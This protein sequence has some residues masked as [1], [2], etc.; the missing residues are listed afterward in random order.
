MNLHVISLINYYMDMLKI[1]QVFDLTRRQNPTETQL[2][3]NGTFRLYPMKSCLHAPKKEYNE[4]DV[5]KGRLRFSKLGH[6][7]S[8]EQPKNDRNSIER[9]NRDLGTA[10]PP[11]V[12]PSGHSTIELPLGTAM[13]FIPTA[14]KRQPQKRTKE[15][16]QNQEGRKPK[17]QQARNQPK[18]GILTQH[19][20]NATGKNKHY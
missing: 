8:P 7:V 10:K 9:N 18:K 16:R 20:N 15:R 6:P 14:A 19:H 5:L 12:E 3:P 13:D 2:L 17:I 1:V 11:R 4:D